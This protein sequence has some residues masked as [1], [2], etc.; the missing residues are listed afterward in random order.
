MRWMAGVS[1][2]SSPSPGVAMKP[3]EQPID[4]VIVAHRVLD[5][6]EMRGGN[7]V[8]DQAQAIGIGR[9]DG[10]AGQRQVESK[11]VLQSREEIRA[12]DIGQKADADLRHRRLD[13][14]RLPR[15]A[16]HRA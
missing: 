11:V 3:I 2:A 1:L 6:M 16:C 5:D 9:A 4:R 15:N 7:V 13:S 8:A 14:P 12:A 10:A